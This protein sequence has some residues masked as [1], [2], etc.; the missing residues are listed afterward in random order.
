MPHKHSSSTHRHSH[1]TSA[2]RLSYKAALGQATDMYEH[3]LEPAAEQKQAHTYPEQQIGTVPPT[4][5]VEQ[6]PLPNSEEYRQGFWA[7][8]LSWDRSAYEGWFVEQ[9]HIQSLLEQKQ[10]LENQLRELAEKLPVAKEMQLKLQT[11][12]NAMQH[13]LAYEQKQWERHH[14]DYKRLMEEEQACYQQKT[15]LTGHYSLFSGILFFVAGLVFMLADLVVSHEIVA[16]A[17]HI[18]GSFEAWSFAVGLAMIPVLL[19]P[20]Y[21]RLIELPYKQQKSRRTKVVYIAFKLLLVGFTLATLLILGLFRYEAYKADQLKESLGQRLAFL[22][23]AD[24]LDATSVEQIQALTMQAE[25]LRQQLVQSRAGLLSFVLSGVL[26]ALAG[27]V[28]LSIGLS[29][30]LAYVQL[31][32]QLPY[33]IRRTERLRHQKQR[34]V[35]HIEQQIRQISSKIDHL[36]CQQRLVDNPDTL[37]KQIQECRGQ[38]ALVSEKLHTHGLEERIY[39]FSH[40]YEQGQLLL[41]QHKQSLLDTVD[42]L[43]QQLQQYEQQ[44]LESQQQ[45]TVFRQQAEHY[46]QQLQQLTAERDKLAALLSA[47]EADYLHLQQMFAQQHAGVDAAPSAV[48]PTAHTPTTGHTEASQA[49]YFRDTEQSLPKHEHTEEKVSQLPPQKRQRKRRSK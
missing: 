36:Q 39:R 16:Y 32:V 7:G 25:Q 10:Q 49:S 45:G 41:A 13:Q 3:L 18:R 37:Q 1:P 15:N 31:W 40:G 27:A 12:I 47:K 14:H 20:A 11:D 43:K 48:E 4:D 6:S 29:V 5:F 22:Q 23:A 34:L 2:H 21:D 33:R 26:F 28:C 17:L 38:L 9:A 19:K 24:E 8:Y 30:L 44:L 35:E 42:Q 46:Q